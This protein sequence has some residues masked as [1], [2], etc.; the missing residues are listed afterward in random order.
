M[1]A[2][3]FNNPSQ[4]KEEQFLRVYLVPDT[5]ILININQVTEVLNVPLEKIV[6]IP[7]MPAWTMGVYNWRGEVLWMV[8][9]GHLVGLTPWH[10]QNYN[11]SDHRAIVVHSSGEKLGLVVN[12]VQDIE[13]LNPGEIKSPPASSVTPEL[14]PFLRGYWLKANGEILIVIDAETIMAA[15]PKP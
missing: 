4:A 13:L 7:Q 5:N 9:L 2:N 15:M 14:V 1:V 6:P 11:K 3:L 12:Q 8:D 10:R